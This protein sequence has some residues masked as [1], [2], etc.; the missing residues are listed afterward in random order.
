MT[1]SLLLLSVFHWKTSITFLNLK[2]VLDKHNRFS[3]YS[4]LE[5]RETMRKYNHLS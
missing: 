4:V 3:V 1:I 2:Y 5:I